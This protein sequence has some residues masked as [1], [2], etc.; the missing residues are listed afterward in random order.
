MRK[1]AQTRPWLS[2]EGVWAWFREAE[3]REAHQSR[4]AIRLT[5]IGPFHAH[6]VATMLG[7]SKQAAQRKY[8]SRVST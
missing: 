2:P 1:P 8:G 5:I 4:L 3:S 6:Q 7:V